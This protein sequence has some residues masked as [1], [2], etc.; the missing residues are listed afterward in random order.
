MCRDVNSQTKVKMVS[1][2]PGL[3]SY[4]RPQG[5]NH[6][7]VSFFPDNL[8]VSLVSLGQKNHFNATF[9]LKGLPF[10]PSLF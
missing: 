7:K 9:N 4:P 3:K 6:M 8:N 1:Q 5:P 10:Y 2:D